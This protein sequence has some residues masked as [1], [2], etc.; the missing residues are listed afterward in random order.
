[1][2][3]RTWRRKPLG[4]RGVCSCPLR[5]DS[6]PA[7]DHRRA[8]RTTFRS[9]ARAARQRALR[10]VRPQHDGG[11][12]VGGD[13]EPAAIGAHPFRGLQLRPIGFRDER[14]KFVVKGSALERFVDVEQHGLRL[15][16][17]RD[18]RPVKPRCVANTQCDLVPRWHRAG[19]GASKHDT[20]D[21]PCSKL[22]SPQPLSACWPLVPACLHPTARRRTCEPTRATRR[23]AREK[24]PAFTRS[25]PDAD[26]RAKAPRGGGDPTGRCRGNRP[27]CP[28]LAVHFSV[29]QRYAQLIAEWR[30]AAAETRKA[31][32]KLT[33]S[34]DAHLNGKGPA[35]DP[36]S[37]DYLR[38][39]RDI[40]HAKLEAA[41][42]YVRKTASGP[43]TGS[44]N[45]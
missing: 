39:L 34:L 12:A 8:R 15:A 9:T 16:H 20:G 33:L 45:L 31:Q 38:K 37:I 43:P 2:R 44:G 11:F 13:D 4:A 26:S 29:S 30:T 5:R 3:S 22:S 7:A 21:L 40:E 27:P 32:A 25:I 23:A 28:T 24:A 14:A 10:Q 41:M 6:S 17:W 36:S 1:M 35:P 42:E 18:P 19:L